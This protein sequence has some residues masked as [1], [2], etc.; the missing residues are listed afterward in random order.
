M[1]KHRMLG[2]F[3][4]VVASALSGAIVAILGGWFWF[5]RV[6]DEET[7][8]LHLSGY[9]VAVPARPDASGRLYGL[10][11]DDRYLLVLTA[12]SSEHA[13][14]YYLSLPGKEIGLPSFGHYVPFLSH[15]FVDREVYAGFDQEEALAADWNTTEREVHIRIRGFKGAKPDGDS[16]RAMRENMPIGYGNE[17]VLTM[18]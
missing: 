11:Y 8:I 16:D 18:K 12:P 17:I 13:E 2:L 15:A 7:T 3:V 14:G 6:C 10:S 5:Q 1:G 4:L 9:R